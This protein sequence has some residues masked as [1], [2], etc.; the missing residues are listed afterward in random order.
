MQSNWQRKSFLC[1]F[2]PVLY[3]LPLSFLHHKPVCISL[4]T[5][6]PTPST[7]VIVN[8]FAMLLCFMSFNF[9]YKF[10]CLPTFFSVVFPSLFVLFFFYFLIRYKV[11][12][13][14]RGKK[15]ESCATFL[16]VIFSLCALIMFIFIFIQRRRHCLLLSPFPWHENINTNYVNLNIMIT[17]RREPSRDTRKPKPGWVKAKREEKLYTKMGFLPCFDVYNAAYDLCIL[18]V[19]NFF[20]RRESHRVCTCMHCRVYIRISIRPNSVSLS[21]SPYISLLFPSYCRSA[22]MYQLT[23][24]WNLLRVIWQLLCEWVAYFNTCAAREGKGASSC[25][26]CPAGHMERPLIAHHRKQSECNVRSEAGCDSDADADSDAGFMPALGTRER[27][28]EWRMEGE[29]GQ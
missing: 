14:V 24:R 13:E 21:F 15:T 29:D 27:C 9:D 17:E 22:S 3:S 10:L 18:F 23:R 2:F 26:S 12:V 6:P 5:S 20:I 11:F 25:P 4:S 28:S 7:R 19:I 1:T 8:I 16:L